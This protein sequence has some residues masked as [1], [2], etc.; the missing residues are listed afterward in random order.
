LSTAYTYLSHGISAD[1]F[2]EEIK[3][4][5]IGVNDDTILAVYFYQKHAA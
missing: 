4:R 3:K 1:E 2:K 5:L